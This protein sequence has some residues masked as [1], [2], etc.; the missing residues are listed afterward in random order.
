MGRTVGVVVV[1]ATPEHHLPLAFLGLPDDVALAPFAVRHRVMDFALSSLLHASVRDVE[2]AVTGTADRL[3]AYRPALIPS[4]GPQRLPRVRPAEVPAGGRLR[5]V[6]AAC[7]ATAGTARGATI[8]ALAGD[9]LLAADLHPLLAAHATRGADVTLA[10]IP[11]LSVTDGHGLLLDLDADGAIA[12]A[13][14]AHATDSPLAAFWTGD[15]AIRAAAL[16]AV[17]AHLDALGACD[18]DAV[19]AALLRGGHLAAGAL[20]GT[21]A[22]GRDPYWS[23]PQTIETYYDAQMALCLPA[24]PLD[25]WARDWGLRAGSSGATPAKVVSDVSGHPAHVLN[26]LLGDGTCVRGAEVVRSVLG[27]GVVVDAGAEI[28]DCLLLDGCRIGRG[29]RVRR[30]VVGAGAVV[31]ADESVGY[32]LVAPAARVLTSGLTLVPPA[33]TSMRPAVVVR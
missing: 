33:A 6:L 2:I 23:D 21:P 31:G 13:A 27:A 1:G 29:A 8:V 4:D 20:G 24:P 32:D 28:E 3:A 11:V 16:P 10:T 15:V 22:T 26:T 25:L 30:T 17:L 18:D 14:V 19:A 7:A 9:H 12:R 5:R